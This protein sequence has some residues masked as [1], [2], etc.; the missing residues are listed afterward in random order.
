MA[1]YL[2]MI[3]GY[4]A[5]VVPQKASIASQKQNRTVQDSLLKKIFGFFAA[6]P[7]TS[8]ARPTHG[9]D[10]YSQ[11]RIETTSVKQL[12]RVASGTHRP[13]P[14]R[15]SDPQCID[16]CNYVITQKTS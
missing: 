7:T 12:N 9:R 5:Q 3:E 14:N 13:T 2:L 10:H 4:M 16:F 1:Q 8:K 11:G 6:P 15:P